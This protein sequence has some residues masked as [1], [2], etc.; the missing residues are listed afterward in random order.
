MLQAIAA[1]PLVER[2]LRELVDFDV[3]DFDPAFG[4]T[5]RLSSG[6]DLRIVACDGAM[7]RFFL[8]GSDGDRHPALYADSEGSAGIIGRDLSGALAT[9]VAAELA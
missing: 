3:A 9:M 7:G 4:S 1:S 5:A 6:V 2:S 8:V